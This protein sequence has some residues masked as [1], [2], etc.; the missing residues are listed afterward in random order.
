MPRN[1]LADPVW[2]AVVESTRLLRVRSER[3]LAVEAKDSGDHAP[4]GCEWTPARRSESVNPGVHDCDVEAET[5]ARS[6]V[7][8][9]QRTFS[10]PFYCL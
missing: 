8:T 1:P 5:T 2:R 10:L 3:T 6:R 7:A 4:T 9:S